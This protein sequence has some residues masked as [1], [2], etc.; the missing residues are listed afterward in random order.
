MKRILFALLDLLAIAFLVGGYIIQY[1]T[2]RKLGMVRWVTFKTSK[3]QEAV[4]VDMLKYAAAI[5]LVLLA[6]LVIRSFVKKRTKM[7]K[8]DTVMVAV[9]VILTVVYLGFALLITSEV[10]RSYYLI[11]P[12][13]GAAPLMVVIRNSLAIWMCKNEK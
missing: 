11:L 2:K 12:M 7:G 8:I 5:V 10:I 3:I 1:F 9:M 4:P 6:V 13:I